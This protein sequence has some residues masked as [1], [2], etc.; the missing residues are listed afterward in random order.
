M[1]FLLLLLLLF[2]APASTDEGWFDR[3]SEGWFWYEKIPEPETNKDE[4]KQLSK[5]AADQPLT[6]SWIRNNIG[7]YLDTAIDHPS[8]KNVSAYLYLDRLVKEKAERFAR[9]GKQVIES[10]PMLDENARRPISPAAAKI[11]DDIASQ[12]K[13]RVLKSIAKISGLV[14][15]YQGNCRL[16][17]LQVKTLQAFCNQ[18]DFSLIPVSTDGVLLPEMGPS[19][20][21]PSPPET[22]NIVRYPALFLMR[23]PDDII[24]L[25]QGIL[26][27]MELAEQVL[28]AAEQHHWITPEQFNKTRITSDTWHQKMPNQ[29]I[30]LLNKASQAPSITD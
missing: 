6:T 13:E 16:C 3:H 8:K 22:L 27:L 15:Y 11:Q 4:A 20:I 30:P 1:F 24:P 29:I 5:T 28:Q 9:I 25:R 18:Y 17:Q 7:H 2:P 21:E 10:D 26:S 12:A 14:F 23:P 19:K